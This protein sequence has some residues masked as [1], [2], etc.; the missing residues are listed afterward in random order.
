M[1]SE[2][3]RKIDAFVAA[4][5]G[6]GGPIQIGTDDKGRTIVTNLPPTLPMFFDAFCTLHGASEAVVADGERLTFADLLA[7]ANRLAPALVSG[8]GID[9]GDRVGI[10][11]RNCPSW[12][13]AYMATLKAGGIATLL[14]GWWT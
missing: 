11:M 7:H 12:I 6:P 10:A 8:F 13:I 5:T 3:D 9:K 4:I 2:L 14:N 1:P